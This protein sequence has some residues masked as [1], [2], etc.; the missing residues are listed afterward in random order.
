MN[1]SV[2]TH[3]QGTAGTVA[4]VGMEEEEECRRRRRLQ[5][6]DVCCVLCA[7]ARVR[8]SHGVPHMHSRALVHSSRFVNKK[9]CSIS[10]VRVCVLALDENV[11]EHPPKNAFAYKCAHALSRAFAA[12]VSLV[13]WEHRRVSSARASLRR[14]RTNC[15]AVGLRLVS[16]A[17]ARA[18][19]RV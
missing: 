14:S 19:S 13:V 3:G 18:R 11:F 15:W 10:C 16:H 6:A 7:C 2:C 12:H 9:K 5:R 17:R 1:R 4:T 8:S